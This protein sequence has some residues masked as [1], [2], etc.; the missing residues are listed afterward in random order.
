MPPC[1]G[2]KGLRL[3]SPFAILSGKERVARL[4]EGFDPCRPCSVKRN[5]VVEEDDRPMP[6]VTGP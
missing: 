5:A 3:R 4:G 2:K 6:V 1:L